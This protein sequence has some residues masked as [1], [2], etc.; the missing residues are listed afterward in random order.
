MYTDILTVGSLYGDAALQDGR[1]EQKTQFAGRD[2]SDYEGVS[3]ELEAERVPELLAALNRMSND[4]QYGN[5]VL[6]SDLRRPIEMTDAVV[7]ELQQLARPTQ[8]KSSGPGSGA[9]GYLPLRVQH[10]CL[11]KETR[12]AGAPQAQ[13]LREATTGMRQTD[14]DTRQSSEAGRK[15]KLLLRLR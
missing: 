11:A 12:D 9:R 7:A 2:F 13:V 5:I 3:I 4:Q 14:E 1:V 15:V 8:T 6:P 10:D